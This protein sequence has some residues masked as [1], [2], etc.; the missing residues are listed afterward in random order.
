MRTFMRHYAQTNEELKQLC[1]EQEKKAEEEQSQ[2]SRS[3][4]FDVVCDEEAIAK[5]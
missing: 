2:P 5:F 1:L 3:A 4:L